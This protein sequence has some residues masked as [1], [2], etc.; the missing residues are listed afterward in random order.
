MSVG[1]R[2]LF[3]ED[4]LYEKQ[5]V[6]PKRNIVIAISIA[7]VVIIALFLSFDLNT[8]DYFALISID[9]NPSLDITID[10]NQNVIDIIP[11]NL[12]AKDLIDNSMITQNI[13]ITI[14]QILVNAEKKNYLTDESNHILISSATW[15]N[16]I[17]YSL[18]EQITTYIEN[19]LELNTNIKVIYIESNHETAFDSIDKGISLGRLELAKISKDD[20]SATKPISEIVQDDKI[21]DNVQ[22]LEDNKDLEQLLNNIE[23]LKALESPS[24]SVLDFLESTEN[25]TGK[26]WEALVE[27]SDELFSSDTLYTLIQFI[28]L[29]D[30]AELLDS[31]AQE[32]LSQFN[33]DYEALEHHQIVQMKNKAIEHW[34]RVKHLSRDYDKLIEGLTNYVGNPEVDIY[35]EKY[36]N[37]S[38][39]DNI[40]TILEE[41][42]ELLHLLK[43]NNDNNGKK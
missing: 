4:D 10:D 24:Q 1:Q 5:V 30:S 3:V 6:T 32:F 41:G 19:E 11:L 38:A 42:S 15:E 16:D 2:I 40:A 43:T 23:Q 29:L 27:E 22:V 28:H 33:T 20:S 21:V 7:A 9:I 8:N 31:E 39:E 12:E 26:D 37:I 13:L 36:N 17:D 14:D 25:L 18:S 34:N 35:L